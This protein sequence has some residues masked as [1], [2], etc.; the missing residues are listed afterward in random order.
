M[1]YKSYLL[2]LLFLHRS[3]DVNADDDAEYDADDDDDNV[4]LAPR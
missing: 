1:C 3:V 2:P 4:S